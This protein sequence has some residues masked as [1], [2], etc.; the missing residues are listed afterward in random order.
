MLLI[1]FFFVLIVDVL[2]P[3]FHYADFCRNFPDF[4]TDCPLVLSRTRFH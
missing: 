4:V 1:L 3:K 2:K